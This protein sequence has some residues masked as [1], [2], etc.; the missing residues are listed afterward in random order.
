MYLSTLVYDIGIG[1]LRGL[2]QLASL[3]HGKARLFQQGR[4]AQHERLLRTFPLKDSG[5]L[6]WFHCASLGEFEQGRPVMEALKNRIP[7]VRILLTFFSPSGY[8]VQKNYVGA[9][10]IFYLPWDT[11][12]NAKWFAEQIKP[13]LAIFVKY[14]FWYHYISALH[15][16]RIPVLSI[17]SIFREDQVFFQ[18]QG[19]LF[20]NMLAKFNHFFVQNQHS[21]ELLQSIG[22]RA[23]TV[24]GDTRFD[25]VHQIIQRAE[26]VQ[27]ARTF[28]NNQMV[29]V[30]GSAWP[31]DM[32]V[33]I[34]FINS[35][36]GQLKFIVA[37]HELKESFLSAIEKGIHGKTVR[38]SMATAD[39]V[40]SA[41]VLLIDNIGLLSRL[42][43][44]GEFAFVGGG[45]AQGLHNILE[46]AC[47]GVPIFFGDRA[48]QKFQEAVDLTTQGG[49][50]PIHDATDLSKIFE[51]LTTQPETLSS[52]ITVTRRYVQQNLGATDKIVSY[53]EPMLSPWKV[54]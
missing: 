1:G 46:A 18:W 38:Y 41:D 13:S 34:P 3:V 15:A 45:F 24:A 35:H 39:N 20:R 54:G 12:K 8:E 6:V 50:F 25:R 16:H 44:Y 33:L 32:D 43:R 23:A 10:H 9:D 11:A 5:P 26:E 7:S 31:E 36:P 14:E 28:K 47:Y 2:Y 37:P 19:G 4:K 52:A 27:I 40:L 42:Y 22:I 30:I 48:Y 49:A 29:M 17:S 51:Q 21:L 53:C